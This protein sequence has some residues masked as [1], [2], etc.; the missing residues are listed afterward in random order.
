MLLAAAAAAMSDCCLFPCCTRVCLEHRERS[1]CCLHT[2]GTVREICIFCC[3]V[4]LLLLIFLNFNL[5]LQRVH[6]ALLADAAAAAASGFECDSVGMFAAAARCAFAF[7]PSPAENAQRKAQFVCFV[8]LPS[9]LWI[10]FHSM[11]CLAAAGHPDDAELPPFTNGT[12]FVHGVSNH[13]TATTT[14]PQQVI[15]SHKTNKPF[16][17]AAS[18][19]QI[20][21]ILVIITSPAAM[22]R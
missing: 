8:R 16:H 18:L 21:V 10:R 3:C 12:I 6:L 4:C 9:L 1:C 14:A 11:L 7:A 13:K 5:N 22:A 15:N 17:R 20:E 2:P 19:T